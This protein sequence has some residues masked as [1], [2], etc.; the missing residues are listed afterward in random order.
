MI[1]MALRNDRNDR[2]G[3]WQAGRRACERSAERAGRAFAL[4]SR[5]QGCS[6]RPIRQMVQW[7]ADSS[8]SA[9]LRD[10]QSPPPSTPA[11][12]TAASRGNDLF[13]EFV[14]MA[15]CVDTLCQPIASA[16]DSLAC[17]RIRFVMPIVWCRVSAHASNRGYAKKSGPRRRI[18]HEIHTSYYGNSL[19]P[20][21]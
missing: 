4:T 1:R 21:R 5:A 7:P 15:F 16:A 6:G 12:P 10:A 17:T 14:R 2:F 8:S 13:R 18:E 9:A 3:A 11:A 20:K 19:T